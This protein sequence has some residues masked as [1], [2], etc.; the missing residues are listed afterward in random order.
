[1]LY[2]SERALAELDSHRIT[3][4]TSTKLSLPFMSGGVS[5]ESS[6]VSE[7]SDR[8][9]VRQG[10]RNARRL[11]RTILRDVWDVTVPGAILDLTVECLRI[12]IMPF[13]LF[14]EYGEDR[15][16]GRVR[17]FW[18]SAQIAPGA[19]R[20]VEASGRLLLL[21]SLDN[22]R[23]QV[24]PDAYSEHR[25]GFSFPSDPSSLSRLVKAELQLVGE[26]VDEHIAS[27]D[28][29]E[30]VSEGS[31]ACF[32]FSQTERAE[33]TLVNDEG[34]LR[35]WWHREVRQARVVAIVSDVSLQADRSNESI[36][37]GRPVCIEDLS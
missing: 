26:Q 33:Q 17:V 4:T 5:R 27:V 21:G 37:L 28:E 2:L 29:Y 14:G 7:S 16:A 20:D 36:V 19:M 23:G 35:R 15:R 22:L 10:L 18:G 11:G 31:A 32:A 3:K 1:M 24:L 13:S 6:R 9:L 25:I 8:D 34:H 30:D 12:G